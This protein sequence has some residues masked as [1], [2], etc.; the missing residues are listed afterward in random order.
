MPQSLIA[1]CLI[2][3]CWKMGLFF[4]AASLSWQP[5]QAMSP[6]V[7]SEQ[8]VQ[9]GIREY[10]AGNYQ[11]AIT[12]WES[13]D[14]TKL[15]LPQQAIVLENLARAYQKTGRTAVEFRYWESAKKIYQQLQQSIEVGRIEIEIAQTLTKQGLSSQAIQLLCP[16]PE[17]QARLDCPSGSAIDRIKANPFLL[18]SGLGSLAEA[19]RVQGKHS[20]AMAWLQFAR[21]TLATSASPPPSLEAS[22]QKSLGNTLVRLADHHYQRSNSFA[23]QGD[24]AEAKVLQQQAIAYDQQA[25]QAYQTSLTLNRD[26]M[27]QLPALLGLLPVQKRLQPNEF[28]RTWQQAY[29]LWQQL[30]DAQNKVYSGL[31]LAKALATEGDRC[32]TDIPKAEQLVKTGWQIAQK[33]QDSRAK[34]FSLGQLGQLQECQGNLAIALNLTKQAQLSAA[35]NVTN[36]DSLY[37]W[38]WQEGRILKAQS[39]LP[40]SREAYQTAVN[41]LESIR[42]ELL[43]SDR[44]L[45]LEFR[46]N[47]EPVYRDLIQLQLNSG[48]ARD[49]AQALATTNSLQLAELQNYFGNDCILNLTQSALAVAAKSNTAV[50]STVMFDDRTAV[51]LSLPNAQPRI[52]WIEGDRSE[53]AQAVNRYRIGLETFYRVYDPQPA[54]QLYR[55]LVQPFEAALQANQINEIIFVPDSIFRTIPIAAL[56]D[57]ESFLIQRYSLATTPSLQLTNPKNLARKDLSILALGLEQEVTV[58]QTLFPLL[59]QITQEIQGVKAEVKNVTSLFNQDFTRDRISRELSQKNYP[60]LHIATHGKFGSQPEDTY[61]VTG[62]QVNPKLTLND[63]DQLIRQSTDPGAGLELL[64]L[65][66]CETA[67]GDDRAALG[68]AGVA[69]QA[70]ARSAIASLWTVNDAST[71]ALAREFYRNLQTGNLNKSQS[72]RQSQ[73]ELL[74]QGGEKSHPYY[75]SAFILI[76]NW[77]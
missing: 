55:W 71:A 59:S 44:T 63:L 34:S 9:Q 70:G 43:N 15:A 26:R 65:T 53:V 41:T 19:Y 39:Q 11:G 72:L 37:L 12:Q 50:L 10:Q 27:E 69:I 51:I 67:V 21:Q 57:G 24:Q 38:Q 31:D 6:I 75:W 2:A 62:D 68:L 3:P 13:I 52:H 58:S 7:A 76:G 35:E 4:F 30:P 36:Q 29:Q 32:P 25:A 40:A 49:L 16:L 5:V 18:V 17:T 74:K 47:I 42:N 23:R 8:S 61:I 66:A 64:T 33:L 56:H 46:E 22:L 28:T 54:Q 1:S 60:I 20:S 77:L 14:R 45:Q 73:L 48:N